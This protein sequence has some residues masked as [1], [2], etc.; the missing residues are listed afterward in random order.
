MAE[1]GKQSP[2]TSAGMDPENNEFATPGKIWR[3]LAAAV[4][5]F[6]LDPASGA[7]STPIADERYTR[8]D[9]GL[10]KPWHGEVFLNPPW[11]T[12]GDGAAKHDWLRK[13]RVERKRP[14]VRRVVVLLP[15][16]TSTQWFHEH[17]LAAE[18][19]CF[20]GP[21]RISFE[22]GDRN[23]SF[24]LLIAVFGPVTDELADTLDHFGA[25]FQGRD[26]YERTEQKQLATDGG[27]RSPSSGSAETCDWCSGS[28]VETVLDTELNR[29]FEVC[30]RHLQA[31]REWE[32]D[33]ETVRTD[34]GRDDQPGPEDDPFACSRCGQPLGEL[35]RVEGEEYCDA[36]LSEMGFAVE[37]YR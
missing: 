6:D 5:G 28:R 14:E 30:E 26:L 29:E 34:G 10:S 4:G 24:G 33:Y 32:T 36:C 31:T 35:K 18:A 27:G 15:V 3:P 9:D 1:S 17:V 21:G 20:V 16:D 25:V 8:D 12:N 37:G 13:V 7:E 11:S 23:P 19:I 2:L 22:G